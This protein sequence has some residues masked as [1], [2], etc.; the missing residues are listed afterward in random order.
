[1]SIFHG[2]PGG[3]QQFLTTKQKCGRNEITTETTFECHFQSMESWGGMKHVDFCGGYNSP[4]K[5]G[6]NL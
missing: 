4:T 3:E 1:M 6:F 2:C 5:E